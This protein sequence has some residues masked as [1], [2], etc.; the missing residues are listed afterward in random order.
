MEPAPLAALYNAAPIILWVED[1][2]TE[3][4]LDTVWQH[5]RRIQ[6]YIGGG[7]ETLEAVV[8]DAYRAGRTC[9]FSLRDRDFG[10]SNRLRWTAKDQHKFALESFEIE[11]FLCDAISLSGIALNTSARTQA[12]I[13][14]WLTARAQAARWW[15]ACRKVISDLR[16]ARQEHFWKHPKRSN[17]TNQTA[18]EQILLDSDW[19][20]QTVPA[21]PG[22]VTETRLR[23][24]LA[25]AHTFYDAQLKAGSWIP[26]FSC[27]ELFED[28]VSWIYTKGRPPGDAG[29]EDLAKAV[30]QKQVQDRRIPQE[31]TELKNALISRL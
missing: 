16:E 20:K 11:C 22:K 2:L 6:M 26:R 10:P 18:A 13:E 15:M 7:H 21:L 31:L 1:Q 30:A 14:Q 8:E 29:K 5:D 28:M 9:V 27:K 4:Y 12:E 24:Q 25:L 23:E 17:V 3:R 19:L